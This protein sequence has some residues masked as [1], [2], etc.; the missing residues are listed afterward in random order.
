[1]SYRTPGK[2]VFQ[3]RKRTVILLRDLD[4]GISKL[5]A[6]LVR[7]DYYAPVPIDAGDIRGALKGLEK[8]TRDIIEA[9]EKG[10]FD[11]IFEEGPS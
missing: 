3:A 5:N 2:K 9:T 8:R 10:E 4:R 11:E 1:M 7:A 6:A